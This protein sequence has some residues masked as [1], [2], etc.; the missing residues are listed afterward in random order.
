[1]VA[2]Q[3]SV[4]RGGR[5]QRF[6]IR[7]NGPSVICRRHRIRIAFESPCEHLP[8]TVLDQLGNDV[9][10]ILE[11]HRAGD[12]A[13]GLLRAR[14]TVAYPAKTGPSFL[15]IENRLS[16]PRRLLPPSI[17]REPPRV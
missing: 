16:V 5:P 1:I 15:R 11:A 14:W 12:R 13:D 9:G 3:P 2:L 17:R 4:E 8:I 7:L 6:L 10:N